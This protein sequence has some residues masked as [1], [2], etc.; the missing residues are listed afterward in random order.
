MAGQPTKYKVEYNKQVEKLCKLGATDKEIG[1]FF[2]VTE[3]TIN[4]WKIK[5]PEFFESIKRGKIEADMNVADSL[6]KRAMGYEHDEVHITSFQGEI[7]KTPIVKHYAPDTTAIMAWLNNRRPDQYRSKQYVESSNTN[8][9][10]NED[11][12]KLTSEERKARI[13]E[14]MEKNKNG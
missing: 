11:V 5:E 12:T 4:N 6:Y 7:T 9:N 8:H 14:L 13:K 10:V 1:D 2:N 3:T